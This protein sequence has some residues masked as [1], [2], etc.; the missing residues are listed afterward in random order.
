MA[1]VTWPSISSALDETIAALDRLNEAQRQRRAA[2]AAELAALT[3]RLGESSEPWT[4]TTAT[5]AP[6]SATTPTR[7]PRPEPRPYVDLPER[8]THGGPFGV[9]VRNKLIEEALR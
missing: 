3:G 5:P 7:R 9:K 1:D 4:E 6:T 8:V 2:A